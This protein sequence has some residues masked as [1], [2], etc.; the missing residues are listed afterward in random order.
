[1]TTPPTTTPKPVL[2]VDVAKGAKLSD[3]AQKL[4][5]PDVTIEQYF[6]S[7]N[8]AQLYPDGI[9]FLA[10]LLTPKSA[11][12]WGCL[13]VWA[14]VDSQERVA[15]E[16]VLRAV[17][18]WLREPQDEHR[19][20]VAAVAQEIGHATAAGM[21][22]K[23]VFL[24]E[25]SISLPGQP[26][27]LAKADS[28]AQLVTLSILTAARFAGASATLGQMRQFLAIGVEVYQGKNSWERA[29]PHREG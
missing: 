6:D 21:L 18:Q 20:A 3:S 1:M 29:K 13:C 14:G 25:G 15:V 12:W 26:D 5:Q 10:R 2:A 4:L 22:G 28:A 24:S 11:I 17:I 9:R 27:V 8:R 7:L 19:R 16:R 23:A